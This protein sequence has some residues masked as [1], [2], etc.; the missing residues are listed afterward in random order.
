VICSV[1]VARGLSGFRTARKGG[2]RDPD[3]FLPNNRQDATI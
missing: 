2:G 1:F 3:L